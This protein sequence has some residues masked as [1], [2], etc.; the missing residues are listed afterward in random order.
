[1]LVRRP[2][3]F[4]IVDRYLPSVTQIDGIEKVWQQHI[5]CNQICTMHSIF[6][7]EIS[8]QNFG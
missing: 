5:L 8:N 7:K 3:F 2:S 6:H 1:M 4:K